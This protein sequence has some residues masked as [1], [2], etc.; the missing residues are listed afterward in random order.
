ML[1]ALAA[2][3]RSRVDVRLILLEPGPLEEAARKKGIG[4][5]VFPWLGGPMLRRPWRIP[6][7]VFKL[8]GWLRREKIDILELNRIRFDALAI[9]LAACRLAGTRFVQRSRMHAQP[10]GRLKKRLLSRADLI[11]AITKGAAAPWYEGRQPQWWLD[12]LGQKLKVIPSSRDIPGLSAIKADRG[13][14][15]ALGIP[16][17]VPLVGM[18]AAVDPRKRQDLFLRAAAL[19]LKQVPEAWFAVVGAPYG[20]VRSA[21]TAYETHLMALAGQPPLVG[22]VVFTGYRDD[23]IVLMKNFTVAVLPSKREALGGVL[24]EALAL[25]VP[26][27]A[28][29]VD[30]IPEVVVDGQTGVLIE[31][32]EPQP[33]AEAIV[34]FIK[35][36][37]FA[38]KI[39]DAGRRSA[40]RWD[41]PAVA[42]EILA[43][44]Q[45]LL[46]RS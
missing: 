15:R 26:V 1:N 10:M 11:V 36:P 8:A 44:Y 12:C 27:V 16:D 2:F 35:E 38:K 39:A 28:S 9:C 41:N 19:V 29:A 34:R 18:V 20:E 45:E 5:E 6:A 25:G 23:A 43:C 3:D 17:G 4:A 14:T 42:R 7:A 33:Y 22:R 46:G 24:I 31:G 37:A 40:E 32:D 13:L 30:G 21:P